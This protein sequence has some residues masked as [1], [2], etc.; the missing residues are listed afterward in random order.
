MNN[1]RI[2]ADVFPVHFLLIGGGFILLAVVGILISIVMGVVAL[3]RRRR[4]RLEQNE[5]PSGRN[6]RT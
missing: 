5:D 1:T 3:V 6:F 4:T 2:I